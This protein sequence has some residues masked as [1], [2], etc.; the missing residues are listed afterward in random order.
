[1]Q[2]RHGLEFSWSWHIEANGVIPSG[3][4][5]GHLLAISTLT[6]S[7]SALP[8]VAF[9]IELTHQESSMSSQNSL[10]G[11]ASIIGR[12]LASID[13]LHNGHPPPGEKARQF[14]LICNS[15]KLACGPVTTADMERLAADLVPQHLARYRRAA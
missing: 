1:M 7:R 15:A 12:R 11:L 13:D 9:V 8:Q 6:K 3:R 14:T 2:P 10:N 4:A 5:V